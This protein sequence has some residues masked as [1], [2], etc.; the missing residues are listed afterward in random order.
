[1]R[2]DPRINGARKR[3]TL[4]GVVTVC[5]FCKSPAPTSGAKCPRCG[6][7]AADHP[8]IAAVGGRNLSTD[9][10][11]DDDGIPEIAR[12]S[13]MGGHAQDHVSSYES[14]SST[15]DSDLMDDDAPGGGA[16]ELDMPPMPA[17]P[18]APELAAPDVPRESL[19]GRSSLEAPPPMAPAAESASRIQAPAAP[20]KPD[21]AAIIAR[22]PDPPEPNKIWLMPVYACKVVIRQFEL[23]MNLTSLRRRRSPD[24]GLYERA[25]KVYEPRS[26]FIGLAITSVILAL[27]TVVFFMPVIL[28]FARSPD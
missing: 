13:N 14:S 6:R 8:S 16:L 24:V 25:L 3:D 26:F 17:P 11:D 1:M 7:L 10:D 15:F 12:G 28:R 2:R 21:A 19:S 4:D 18:P 22:Y 9:F 20:P 23:R 5:P 27:A